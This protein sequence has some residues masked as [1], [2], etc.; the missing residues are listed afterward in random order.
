MS[1]PES[2]GFSVSGCSAFNETRHLAELL[3][4]FCCKSPGIFHRIQ[5]EFKQKKKII[6]DA[7]FTSFR[8]FLSLEQ[9]EKCLI[10]VVHLFHSFTH[11][12]CLA[13]S[14]NPSQLLLLVLCSFA[15]K[16]RV[17]EIDIVGYPNNFVLNQNDKIIEGAGITTFYRIFC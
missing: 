1:Y 12:R 8:R 2:T 16:I 4:V 7:L 17:V 14:F 5:V 11:W 3:R 6:I 9:L 13:I 10:S 15:Y